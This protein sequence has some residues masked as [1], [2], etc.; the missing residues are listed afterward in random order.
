M[1]RFSVP[2]TVYGPLRVAIYL[3][4]AYL[5]STSTEHIRVFTAHFDDLIRSAIMQPPEV[6][7]YLE[8]LLAAVSD[9]ADAGAPN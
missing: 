2:F 7:R 1:Q 9:G 8:T 5:V 6:F 3:G 4:G